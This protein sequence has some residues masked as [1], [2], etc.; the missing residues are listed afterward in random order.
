MPWHQWSQGSNR[1][2]VGRT[3]NWQPDKWVL[4]RSKFWQRITKC[5]VQFWPTISLW[6][7]CVPVRA[8]DVPLP[9][10]PTNP[11]CTPLKHR[12]QPSRFRVLPLAEQHLKGKLRHHPQHHYQHLLDLH[13]SPLAK[14]GKWEEDMKHY[15][16][17]SA[18]IR[19]SSRVKLSY[20]D[21]SQN[22]FLHGI[23]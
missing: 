21:N 16:Q 9:L 1:N 17:C 23:H 12:I 19:A 14:V 13:T 10:L 7:V 3:R 5:S 11:F 2:S 4:C 8:H 6:W 15:Q 22:T 20:S 18:L